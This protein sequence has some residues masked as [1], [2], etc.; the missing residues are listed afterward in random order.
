[1]LS[2]VQEICD[3]VGILA[4]GQLVREGRVE[5]LLAVRD[6]TEFVLDE[7]SPE[8]VAALRDAAEKLGLKVVSSGRAQTTLENL[9]LE[10]IEPGASPDAGSGKN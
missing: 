10:A 9:F 2:Q 6:R 7:V 1:L 4:R 3:R 8:K 5:D